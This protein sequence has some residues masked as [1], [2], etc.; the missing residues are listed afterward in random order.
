MLQ[1]VL[2]SQAEVLSLSLLTLRIGPGAIFWHTFSPF[3]SSATNCKWIAEA[4]EKGQGEAGQGPCGHS[5]SRGASPPTLSSLSVCLGAQWQWIS[6]LR[7]V[8][9]LSFARWPREVP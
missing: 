9:G 7:G 5:L 4:G 1:L 8:P 3:P 2:T 6:A